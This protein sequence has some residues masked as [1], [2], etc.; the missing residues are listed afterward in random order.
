MKLKIIRK[1]SFT[2][3]ESEFKI[4]IIWMPEKMNPT[5]ANKLLKILEEPPDKTL[6]LLVCENEDQLLRT[7]LSRTQLVKI[8]KIPDHLM[9][10]ALTERNSIEDTLATGIVHLADGNYNAAIH[11]INDNEQAQQNFASFKQWMRLCL[12][13][14]APKIISWVDDISASSVGR[15]RQKNFL[16]YSIHMVRECLML[17]YGELELVRLEGEELEFVKKFAPFINGSN[18]EEF[19]EE[20]N[21]AS[22][23]I[24]RNA[25]PKILFM[26]LSFRVNELLNK[27][28][29]AK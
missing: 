28:A 27:Q 22:Y 18:C 14:D 3:Y 6:F 8:N 19:T 25:S 7:I 12:H 13:F 29:I 26:D 9:R 20:L 24:E 5:A 21:K 15:E 1:L 10:L 2:T 17:N 23:H 4:M 11:L 16:A